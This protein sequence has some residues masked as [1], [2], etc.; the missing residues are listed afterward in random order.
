MISGAGFQILETHPLFIFEPIGF[1]KYSSVK[2]VNASFHF[3][4]NILLTIVVLLISA[5][6]IC[7]K[8][9]KIGANNIYLVAR[10]PPAG[11]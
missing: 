6:N 2:S 8:A 4:L 11:A 3:P 5:S 9:L 1:S 10:K 7:L